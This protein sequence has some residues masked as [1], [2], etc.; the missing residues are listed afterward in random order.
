MYACLPACLSTLHT[1]HAHTRKC[2]CSRQ[3]PLNPGKLLHTSLR[4]YLAQYAPPPKLVLLKLNSGG[5]YLLSSCTD[6]R[7]YSCDG[8]AGWLHVESQSTNLHF[9]FA[10]VGTRLNQYSSSPFWE[11]GLIHNCVS[12]QTLVNMGL[13][14]VAPSLSQNGYPLW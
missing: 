4:S 5:R 1:S 7:R 14:H 10:H 11:G 12:R 3:G 9:L 2:Q 8:R 13:P 6:V